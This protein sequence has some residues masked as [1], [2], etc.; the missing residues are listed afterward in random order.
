MHGNKVN[1]MNI[2][3]RIPLM[4][5]YFNLNGIFFFLELVVVIRSIK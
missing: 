1:E 3:N 4:C 5:I 2:I